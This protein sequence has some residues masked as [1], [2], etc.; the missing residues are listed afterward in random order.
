MGTIKCAI[1]LDW[2]LFL[3][4]I[5][6]A[7]HIARKIILIVVWRRAKDPSIAQTK[8]DLFFILLV[9]LPEIGLF[10]WGNCIIYSDDMD[11][12]R[13]DSTTDDSK[14]V[15]GMWITALVLIIYGYFYMLFSCVVCV[16]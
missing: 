4:L 7:C 10:I 14:H 12:C 8:F 3:Y 15:E 11:Q 16:I 9:V 6:Q 2:W 5:V 13:S 1:L